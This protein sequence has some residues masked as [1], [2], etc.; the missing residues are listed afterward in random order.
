MLTDSEPHRYGEAGFRLL[1]LSD[2]EL[3]WLER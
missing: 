2:D 1:G 3:L